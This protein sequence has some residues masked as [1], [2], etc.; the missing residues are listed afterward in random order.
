MLGS[1]GDTT[2]SALLRIACSL[3]GDIAIFIIELGANDFLRGLAPTLIYDNLQAMKSRVKLECPRASILTLGITLP[4]WANTSRGNG[5]SGIYEKLARENNTAIVPSFLKNVS[6]KRALNMPDGV[7]PLASGY[8]IPV[9]NI[10]P[11]IYALIE[12]RTISDYT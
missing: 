3:Q 6:S 7:H 11:E 9:E 4:Q 2:A 10:W 1:A 12:A 8:Q 5:Y